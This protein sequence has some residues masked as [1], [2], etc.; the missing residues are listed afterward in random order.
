MPVFS[1]RKAFA[2]DVDFLVSLF[3]HE[4]VSAILNAPT[5][6]MFRAS[7]DDPSTEIYI[8]EADG[9]PIGNFLIANQEWL[10]EFK[11]LAVSTPK[12][13]AGTF[14]VEWGLSHAFEGSG[15]HRV[16]C[17]VREDNPHMIAILERLGFAREGTY[18]DGFRDAQA[19]EF[20]DLYPYGILAAEFTPRSKTL[21][22]PIPP[23][24]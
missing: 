8:I 2:D 7:F 5:A 17:E 4:H 14:A 6:A 3:K 18:R 22:S 1:V 16:F 10:F 13:G 11:V 21:L 9:E 23:N 12:R 24:Q 19:G 15:A 20:R